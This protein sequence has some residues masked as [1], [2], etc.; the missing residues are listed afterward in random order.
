MAFST[1]TNKARVE[2]GVSPAEFGRDHD[3]ADQFDDHLAFFLR[4]GFAP[5]LFPLCAHDYLCVLNCFKR[6]IILVAVISRVNPIGDVLLIDA[7]R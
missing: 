7:K 6:K 4:A 5:G 3:F 1:A 2:V